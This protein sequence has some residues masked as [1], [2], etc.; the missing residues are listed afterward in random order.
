VNFLARE[1]EKYVNDVVPSVR[2]I[3]GFCRVN[4]DFLALIL[5][6]KYHMDR[7]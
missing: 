2:K 3:Y 5:K 6:E 4:K 7:V 1:K